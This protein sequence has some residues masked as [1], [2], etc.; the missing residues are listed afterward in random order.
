MLLVEACHAAH[1]RQAR[2]GS[3]D[4]EPAG[5]ETSRKPLRLPN[6]QQSSASLKGRLHVTSSPRSL[7]L[8]TTSRLYIQS[9]GP[10]RHRT[11]INLYLCMNVYTNTK[12]RQSQLAPGRKTRPVAHDFVNKLSRCTRMAEAV[13]GSHVHPDEITHRRKCRLG[14]L[15]HEVEAPYCVRDRA[16]CTVC[17]Q[18]SSRRRRIASGNA[19]EEKPLRY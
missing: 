12:S 14:A 15:I 10:R 13:S 4:C 9:Y 1:G 11:M 8:G 7:N 16:S 19:N 18:T 3:T 6:F 5:A 2:S 17:R